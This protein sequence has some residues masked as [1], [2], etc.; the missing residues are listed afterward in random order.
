MPHEVEILETPAVHNRGFHAAGIATMALNQLRHRLQGYRTPRPAAAPDISAALVYDDAV[1]RNWTDH[2]AHYLG[3]DA[4]LPG[5]QILELGPGPDLGTGLLL[6]ARGGG[7]YCA[8]DAHSL[9]GPDAPASHEALSDAIADLEK[10]DDESRRG[11]RE[12]ASGAGG[13]GGR[14][15]YRHIPNFDLDELEENSVDLV[16]SHSSIEHFHDVD[17]TI[18]SLARCARAGAHF[19]AEIDLQ[20]HTRWFR[21]HDP[22]NIYRYARPLYRS[23]CFPGSPNRVR[24][25]DYLDSLDR[26]GWTNPRF[27]PRRVLASDYV[28]AVEPS[29]CQE[30]RGDVERL[31]WMSVVLCATRRSESRFRRSST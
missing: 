17:R 25:D 14:L 19:V 13:S 5:R 27:Y 18:Q 9:L 3:G 16:V 10:L 23:L 29:L 2:L 6:L 28:K 26:H 7:N 15:A 11:L 12:V 22:L 24:P 4:A 8:V 20:T 31:A 30:F 1:V 21:D